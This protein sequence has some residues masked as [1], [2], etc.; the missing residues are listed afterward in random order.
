VKIELI[1]K[2]FKQFE[3]DQKI[4]KKNLMLVLD[5]IILETSDEYGKVTMTIQ[6]ERKDNNDNKGSKE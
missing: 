6:Y 4:I 1:D 2:L 3:Q 5:K